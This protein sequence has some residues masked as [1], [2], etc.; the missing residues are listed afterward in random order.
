MLDKSSKTAG[1]VLLPDY[2]KPLKYDLKLTPDLQKFTFAG[3]IA[4]ECA[5]SDAAAEHK[6]ITLHAKELLFKSAEIQFQDGD[7]KKTLEAE[8]VS[9]IASMASMAM[10]QSS[11]LTV[12]HRNHAIN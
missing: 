1:R 2:I 9:E 12:N 7:A 11:K 4:I 10:V 5:T 6:K 8:E 3:A